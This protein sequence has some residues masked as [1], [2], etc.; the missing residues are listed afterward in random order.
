GTTAQAIIA[1]LM[2]EEP[3]A[4]TVLRRTVPMHVDAA[5]RR[6]LHKLPADRWKSAREFADSLAGAGTAF[7][8]PSA[9]PEAGWRTG[10]RGA[11]W[12]LAAAAMIVAAVALRGKSRPVVDPATLRFPLAV[13]D[14]ERLA[15]SSGVPFAISF[16]E[17][18][19]AFV[20]IGPAGTR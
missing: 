4:V 3:R 10:L 18:S 14:S 1:K 17:R 12:A 16:D 20:A 2:T 6:A 5:V 13:P 9:T 8:A 11:P 7:V 15:I 19:V